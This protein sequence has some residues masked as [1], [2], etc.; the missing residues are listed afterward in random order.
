MGFSM[1]DDEKLFID[2]RDRQILLIWDD[3]Q[4]VCTAYH[5]EKKVG[6]F[7]FREIDDELS[8]KI[9]LLLTHCHLE[10]EPGFTNCGIGRAIVEFVKE[11]DYVVLMRRHDGIKRDDGS[12][13]TESAP[14]FADA[15]EKKGLIC[16][17]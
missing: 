9:L 4:T 16:R 17:Y 14:G 1:S 10:D 13:L 5:D 15:L 3:F 11:Y 6:C 8:S 12:H 7:R 2:K